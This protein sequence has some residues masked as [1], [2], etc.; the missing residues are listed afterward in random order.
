MMTTLRE[1]WMGWSFPKGHNSRF[2]WDL[3]NSEASLQT[4]IVLRAL[5]PFRPNR[6]QPLCQQ[7]FFYKLFDLVLSGRKTGTAR[8]GKKIL[9]EKT[10]EIGPKM[11]TEKRIRPR[12]RHKHGEGGRDTKQLK[13]K[14]F[15]FG[16]VKG[17]GTTGFAVCFYIWMYF[18]LLCMLGSQ[19]QSRK[20][21]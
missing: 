17:E 14:N 12:V 7:G 16:G 4:W 9:Q 19:I 10:W 1:K 15:F 18:F 11:T 13:R 20:K 6:Q 2:F 8:R 5:D 21:H 3:K